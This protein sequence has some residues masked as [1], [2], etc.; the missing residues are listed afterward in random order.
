[1]L[2]EANIPLYKVEHASFRNFF[3]KYTMKVLPHQ[4]TLRKT[5]LIEKVYGAT[6]DR[7]RGGDSRIWVSMDETTDLK[8]QFVMNTIV[9]RMDASEPTKPHLLSSEVV[10]RMN[11]ATIAQAFC[12]AMNLL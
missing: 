6:I 8:G 10:E 12:N 5:Y 11:P 2:L 1:M 7:I 3:E 9:G 4:T